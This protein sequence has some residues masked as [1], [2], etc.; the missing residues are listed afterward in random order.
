[1]TSLAI[2]VFVLGI[3]WLAVWR[4]KL[5][6]L[7]IWGGFILAVAAV[8]AGGVAWH[9]TYGNR[10]AVYPVGNGTAIFPLADAWRALSESRDET[11]F[12]E[13]LRPI[14]IPDSLKAELWNV[15][16]VM[17][18]HGDLHTKRGWRVVTP[19]DSKQIDFEQYR[20]DKTA[21]TNNKEFFPLTPAMLFVPGVGP[22]D[23]PDKFDAGDFYKA[24]S[25]VLP[26]IAVQSFPCEWSNSTSLDCHLIGSVTSSAHAGDMFDRVAAEKG[27]SFDVK[28]YD[29]PSRSSP[30]ADCAVIG[31]ESQMDI[32]FPPPSQTRGFNHFFTFNNVPQ[33]KGVLMYT[34]EV[35][36][37]E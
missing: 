26:T 16:D 10:Q 1:M 17:S 37:T 30:L 31:D 19:F 32:T 11:D 29:C 3:I 21:V 12:A 33:R 25:Q 8:I 7:L 15:K 6:Q 22:I 13:R 4:G 5:K 35:L 14:D 2:A 24:Y 18:G 27:T 20:A 34:L 23:T 28:L 36:H 9:F